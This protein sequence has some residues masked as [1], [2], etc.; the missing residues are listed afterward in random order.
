MRDF[1]KIMNQATA[2][3]PEPIVPTLRNEHHALVPAKPI[4]TD[5]TA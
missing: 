3:N 5:L 4:C 2:D 1:S